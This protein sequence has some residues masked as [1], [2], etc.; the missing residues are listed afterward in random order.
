MFNRRKLLMG[1]AAAWALP[2]FKLPMARAIGRLAPPRFASFPF[3]LGVASGDPTA[4]SVVLWTRLAPDPLR[5]G[6]MPTAPM[7]VDWSIADDE[8]MGN[9]ILRGTEIAT[10]ELGHSVHVEAQGLEP[11]RWYFYQAF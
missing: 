6:G 7:E 4:D 3:T 9:T 2:A 11:D 1:T 5:G 10:P 8:S